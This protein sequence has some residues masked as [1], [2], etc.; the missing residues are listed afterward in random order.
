MDSGHDLYAYK[1]PE[2]PLSLLYSIR[3]FEAKDE[4][5][6]YA[7]AANLYEE[8]IEAPMGNYHILPKSSTVCQSFNFS[9]S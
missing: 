8:E 5:A 2:V 4:K 9:F 7:L 1:Y 6:V 3:P